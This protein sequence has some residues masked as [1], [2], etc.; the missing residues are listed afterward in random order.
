MT[1]AVTA[2]LGFRAAG[3][4][5]GIK[6]TGVP[7]LMMLAA[8]EACTAAAVFTTNLATAAPVIVSR[9][10]L[11]GGRARAVIVTSGC[12]NAATGE[13]GLADAREMA[14]LGAEALGSS[15]SEIVV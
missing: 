12:A 15:P 8:D 10:H 9:E 1:G 6:P 5:A 4:S 11:A 3:L 14:R 13:G 7:D 2:P